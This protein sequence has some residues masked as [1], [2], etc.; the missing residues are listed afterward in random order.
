[1]QGLPGMRRSRAGAGLIRVLLPEEGPFIA[2]AFILSRLACASGRRPSAKSHAAVVW[3]LRLFSPSVRASESLSQRAC[4]A[5]HLRNQQSADDIPLVSCHSTSPAPRGP[6][7]ISILV[8]IRAPPFIFAV[9][10]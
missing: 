1:V 7:S 8:H 10:I 4:A 5:L 3:S 6:I 9:V 2:Y